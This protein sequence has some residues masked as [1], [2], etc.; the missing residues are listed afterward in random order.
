MGLR[1][2]SPMFYVLMNLMSVD[3][4]INRNRYDVECAFNLFYCGRLSRQRLLDKHTERNRLFL[5]WNVL[6]THYL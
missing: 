3:E 2:N 6:F 1:L 5:A 4:E